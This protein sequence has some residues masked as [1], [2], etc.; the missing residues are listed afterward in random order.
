MNW[1]VMFVVSFFLPVVQP[2]VQQS[3]QKVQIKMQQ[4]LQAVQR[5]EPL[6]VYHNNEWWKYEG[7]QWLVWRQTTGG[8]Q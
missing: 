6:I 2:V 5:Q 4:R 3:V 7:G 1:L 8:Q